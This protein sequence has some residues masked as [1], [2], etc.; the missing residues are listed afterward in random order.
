MSESRAAL[1]GFEETR[2]QQGAF[3]RLS[4]DALAAFEEHGSR[5]ATTEGELLFAEGDESYDFFVVASGQVAIVADLGRPEERVI[6]VHG[7]RRFLG[8]MNLLTGEGVYLSARV[9][10]PGEVIQV[11]AA[12]LRKLVGGQPGLGDLILGAYLARRAILIG[13]G[14]GPRV[15]GSRFSP[16][17]RRLRVFLARNRLPHG[18]IDLEEDAGADALLRELGVEPHETPIVL[19]GEQVLRNPS[20]AEV[21]RAVGLHPPSGAEAVCD[22]LVVGAGPAGLAASVYGASEGLSTV[23]LDAVAAGG[24][25]ATSTRIENLL[26][27]PTGISGME[28][29]ERARVQADKFGARLVVPAEAVG[30]CRHEDHYRVRLLDGESIEARTVI[31]AT[32]ARYRELRVARI[33]ELIGLGVYYAATPMEARMCSGSHVVIVGG[34]NSAGQAAVFLSQH[35]AKVTMMIRGGDLGRT[36]SRYLIDQIERIATIELRTHTEVA[37][38]EGGRTVEGILVEDRRSGER[39]RLDATALFVFIG[40]DPHTGW[41]GDE[42]ALDAKGFVLTGADL[43]GHIE[44]EAPPLLLETS[45]PGVFAVGDARSG[46]LK[47]VASAVGEGSIAVRLVH[48]HLAE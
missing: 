35:A 21:A 23:A 46:A 14:T 9:V 19:R 39:T 13:L 24:Q 41:L 2:D 5:R 32:G 38:L 7:Q 45:R 4:D 15:I 28:L 11:P 43:D 10:E 1:P 33:D 36:M 12:T 16:D 22:L 37:E 34:G 17:T 30:F 8:E 18:F 40:A 44:T 6:G 20:N 48:Q 29:A 47:R 31:I 25:A 26:G 3:P 27:F 42:L